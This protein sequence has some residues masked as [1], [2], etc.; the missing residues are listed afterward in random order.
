MPFTEICVARR[1]CSS[2]DGA[3]RLW[4]PT[5]RVDNKGRYDADGNVPGRE[6]SVFCGTYKRPSPP[7]HY[8]QIPIAPPC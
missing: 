5:F 3:R 2:N 1:R 8:M 6:L 7:L 4:G